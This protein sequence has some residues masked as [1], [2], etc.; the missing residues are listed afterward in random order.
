VLV[1]GKEV[2]NTGW[3]FKLVGKETFLVGKHKACV[4]IE[5]NGLNYNY[6]L[7]VDGKTLKKFVENRRKACRTWLPRVNGQ[8]HRVV[9]EKDNLDV[10]VDGERLDAVGEFTENGTETH[11][12]IDGHSAVILAVT[13]GKRRE[14]IIH[15]LFLDNVQI[16]DITEVDG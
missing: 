6:T 10:W 5:A 9:L 14:G 8:I 3:Q 4:S 1:D 7:E 2:I 11:F 13:S 15:N 16:G 12:V